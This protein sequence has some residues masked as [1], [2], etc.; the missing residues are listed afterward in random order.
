MFKRK[1]R[2]LYFLPFAVLF[3]LF[4]IGA[5]RVLSFKTAHGIRQARDLYAQP[6]NSI[7][8]VFMGSSH[9]HCDINT[10]LLYE[11]YGITAYDYSAAEQPLW[12]TYYYLQEVCK[13]QNPK[14]VV[15]DLYSP[16]AYLPDYQYTWLKDNLNGVRF[17][18]NKLH[19]L[20]DACEPGDYK[21][22]FPSMATYHARYKELTAEDWD[23][24]T[25]SK[26][27][28]A[29]F[30]GY[31]PYRSTASFETPQLK[32]SYAEES[33]MTD[34]S[35]EYLLKI[36][37][38]TRIHNIDLYLF[39]APYVVKPEHEP[40]Y[41]KI[42]EIAEEHDIPYRDFNYEYTDM[43]LDFTKHMNDDSHLNYNGS[44]LF[45]G[46]L[47]NILTQTYDLPDHRGDAYYE[48]WERHVQEI[49]EL[50]EASQ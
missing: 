46:Y 14:L 42:K 25:M 12:I 16:A 30:K 5:D 7:D 49:K 31:T 43:G 33:W 36:I 17:S 13:T 28:R 8:V 9:I 26:E 21:D 48:S 20:Y 41:W 34:K 23:Y 24:L 1:Y 3:C 32:D 40:I 22:Y 15:L 37:E 47:A 19:M 10:A 18:F 35:K 38:Y 44:T 6:K 11:Q 4:Y 29:S 50:A 45:T 39:V 2:K 27:V